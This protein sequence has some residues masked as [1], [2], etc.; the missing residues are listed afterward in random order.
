VTSVRRARLEDA[1]DVAALLTELGYPDNRLDDV[2]QRLSMWTQQSHGAVLVAESSGEVVG[3]VGVVAVPYLEREG[4][5]GRLVAL[6]VAARFRR[7]GIA[8]NLVEAAEEQALRHGCITMEVTSARNRTESHRFYR[9]LGY[10]EWS[11]RSARYLKDL[12]PG[13]LAG[14]HGARQ[15]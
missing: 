9:R 5:W 2:R 4:W 11:F 15:S 3:V 10:E 1:A 6:V 14:S 12:V 8:R 13:A 7:Q